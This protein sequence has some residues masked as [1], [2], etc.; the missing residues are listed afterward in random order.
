[1]DL[2][3]T[4]QHAASIASLLE[5]CW[6]LAEGGSGTASLLFQPSE[7]TPAQKSFTFS[8]VVDH[9][10]KLTTNCQLIVSDSSKDGALATKCSGTARIVLELLESQAPRI[11]T[12]EWHIFRN[13]WNDFCQSETINNAK[14]S[15]AQHS[16]ELKTWL[17]EL[18]RSAE[19]TLVS[20]HSS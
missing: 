11:R 10:R 17:V 16:A 20:E 7:Q 9:L 15:C 5:F 6:T 2:D 14:R 12:T 8:Q 19:D 4:L 3:E 13:G 1:M 18:M